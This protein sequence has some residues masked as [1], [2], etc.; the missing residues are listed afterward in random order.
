MIYVNKMTACEKDIL[1][2]IAISAQRSNKTIIL[3]DAMAVTDDQAVTQGLTGGTTLVGVTGTPPLIPFTLSSH[4]IAPAPMDLSAITGRDFPG[5]RHDRNIGT[6]CWGR[7]HWSGSSGTRPD[8]KPGDPVNGYRWH[9][10]QRRRMGGFSRRPGPLDS[11]NF[12][13]VETYEGTASEEPG[14]EYK[15]SGTGRDASEGKQKQN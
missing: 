5:N 13:I 14:L 8:W 4:P 3:N 7:G 1:S 11:G 15:D 10:G 2:A 6:R 12:H 9:G